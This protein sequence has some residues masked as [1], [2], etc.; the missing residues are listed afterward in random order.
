MVEHG[1]FHKD[2]FRG[3]SFWSA[4][5]KLHLNPGAPEKRT[6]FLEYEL[7]FVKVLTPKSLCPENCVGLKGAAGLAL[8][9]V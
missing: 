2:P 4:G 6:R 3:Q 8:A 7:I 9:T 5:E 1:A